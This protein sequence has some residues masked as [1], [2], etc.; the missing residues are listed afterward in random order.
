[1]S[2]GAVLKKGNLSVIASGLPEHV[3]EIGQQLAWMSAAMSSSDQSTL[4]ENTPNIDHITLDDLTQRKV[5]CNIGIKSKPHHKPESHNAE[6]Q[7]WHNMFHNPVIAC[8]FPI[9]SRSTSTLNTGLEMSLDIMA[10]MTDTRY[11][12]VFNSGT[13]IKGFSSM[14]VPTGRSEDVLLWHYLFKKN[15]GE[16]ISYLDYQLPYIDVE[17]AQLETSRHI[18]GWCSDADSLVG[19]LLQVPTRVRIEKTK[20]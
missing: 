15:A 14:L 20:H 6:G 19:T 12:N 4:C 5:S 9:R 11:I 17:M 1:M 2:L 8:G 10:A 16:H 7:C 18:L 3:A 13:F